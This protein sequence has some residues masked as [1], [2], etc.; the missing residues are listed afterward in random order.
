MGL[1]DQLLATGMARG[2]F[3][4]GTQIA[5]GD[6][7]KIIWDAH[8]ELIFRHN[9]NIAP[10]HAYKAP[11]LEWIGFH[12]GSRIYNRQEG[13]RWIWNYEFR[14]IPGEMYFTR[15]EKRFAEHVGAD[16]FVF[17]EPH[18]PE[19]KTVAP[20]KEWPPERYGE[21]ARRLVSQGYRIVQPWYPTAKYILPTAK[22]VGTPDFRR[23]LA[24]MKHAA[25]YI[26][27][28]G[29][30]HH[31]AA[32]IGKP[33][34]VLFGGFVPPKVTGYETHTNLTGGV[35]EFC[36]SLSA[37]DHCRAAMLAISVEE[38]VDAALRHLKGS[39]P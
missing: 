15:E 25:L 19:H 14:A 12:R 39:G 26:G 7:Q 13:G 29:G 18:V 1:G 27:P 20:N 36:G 5:F 21:V 3:D 30:L 28:E 35:T 4:R 31:G 22:C 8:S 16:G 10:P 24:V 11:N 32:A 37:C 38:V 17:M 34:V 9:P 6:G 23:A 33:A 2:A